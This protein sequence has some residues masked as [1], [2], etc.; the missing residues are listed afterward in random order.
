M[1]FKIDN[2]ATAPKQRTAW[3]VLNF[4]GRYLY[5]P[6]YPDKKGGSD[7]TAGAVIERSKGR[8]REFKRAAS[9]I[10]VYLTKDV[11]S[12]AIW[13]SVVVEVAVSPKDW[14]HT[15][16]DGRMA[17]YDKVRVKVKQPYIDW[18]S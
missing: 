2:D 3:K 8:T 4:D 6:N 14:L 16:I 1:C 5:S 10:Y 17:T 7:W 11:A 18:Y 12:H 13:L 9:G 15:S